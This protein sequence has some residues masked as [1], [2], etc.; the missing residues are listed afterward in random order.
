VTVQLWSRPD[1]APTSGTLRILGPEVLPPFTIGEDGIW[2]GQLR[3]GEW[4]TLATAPG[5][6]IGGDD[7]SVEP[8]VERISTRV[9]LG[10]IEVELT[11][12][13]VNIDDTLYFRLGSAE[14]AN[15]A[16]DSLQAVARTL[17]S[18]PEVRRVRIEGHADRSGSAERN[19]EL[20]ELRA[21]SVY[22]ALIELGV[23]PYRLVPIG[24]GDARPV[25]METTEGEAQ[26]RRVVFRIL[27]ITEA[28][29]ITADSAR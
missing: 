20:S 25:A 26:N 4:E 9:A 7:L 11:K 22:K 19:L 16:Q 29:Q 6:G 14:L 3:P 10:S 12:S 21:Q 8:G 24:Y 15:E 17:R 5:L 1:D 2:E 13:E 27:E 23:E 28:V 18:R